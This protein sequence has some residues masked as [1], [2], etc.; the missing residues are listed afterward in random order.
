[1][2]IEESDQNE[3]DLAVDYLS[4]YGIGDIKEFSV[5]IECMISGLYKK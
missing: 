1:M 4:F 5:M 3:F 2:R